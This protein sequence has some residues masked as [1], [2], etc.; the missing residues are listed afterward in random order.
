MT[1]RRTFSILAVAAASFGLAAC[2]D[3]YD[4]PYGYS[5]AAV[6][7][8]AGYYS[9]PYYGWYQNYYYPGTGIYIYDRRGVRQRW[10]GAHRNYWQGQRQYYRDQRSWGQR[11]P[12][13]SGWRGPPP[14]EYRGRRGSRR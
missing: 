4:R 1:V 6:G 2:A 3:Y 13:W 7:Y 10:S 11:Q 8:G 14:R 12:N 5:S 9:Q